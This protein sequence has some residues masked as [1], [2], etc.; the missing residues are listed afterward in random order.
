MKKFFILSNRDHFKNR[1]LEILSF[2]NR[3]SR[4]QQ[5]QNNREVVTRQHGCAG[6]SMPL[7]AN[8]LNVCVLR[9]F[10]FSSFQKWAMCGSVIKFQPW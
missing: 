7:F 4:Q 2:E 1:L 6:L 3:G 5:Q 9:K 8:T 10:Y